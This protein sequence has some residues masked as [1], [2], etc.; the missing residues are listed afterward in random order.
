MPVFALRLTMPG[1]F[2]HVAY[3]RADRADEP[4]EEPAG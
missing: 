1:H 3:R 4:A 2:W